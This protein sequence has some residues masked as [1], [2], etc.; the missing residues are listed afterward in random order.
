MSLV[1]LSLTALATPAIAADSPSGLSTVVI[2]AAT[3]P[4][5]LTQALPSVSVLTRVQIERSGEKNLSTLLQ[6]IAGIQITSN[7]GPGHS[8]TPYLEGFGGTDA[9]VL[10]LLDGVPLTAEDASGGGDYLE[11]LTTDQI[12]RIEVIHGNVSAIYGSGAIGGVILITTRE[13]GRKP[14]TELSLTAGSR[15]T[16]TASANA[17]GE[18]DHTR[19]QIGVS[20]YT[21]AGIPSINPAE[22][23]FVT[24]NS[25]DGY[26]NITANGSLVRELG[27]HQQLGARAFLSDGRYSYDN[28]SAGGRTKQSLL[29]IF[30][31]NR[32]GAIWTSHLSLS[33]QRT[34]NVNLGSYPATYRSTHLDVLWRNVIRISKAWTLTGGATH[35]HQSVTSA[36]QGG[37]PSVSRNVTAIFAGVNG[38]F[39]GN[40]IQLNLRHDQFDGYASTKNTYYAGYGRQLGHGFEAIV[41]YSSAF[42]VPPLGYLYYSNPYWAANPLLKP[43]SAHTVQTALQWSGR[44][45]LVRATLFQTT[46]GDMW[47]FGSTPNGLT[48][49]ANIARTRTRG[50]ELTARGTWRRWSYD[51]NVTLQ[52]PLAVS[53]PGDP[54][55]QRLARSIANVN[56]EYEFRRFAAGVLVH[57]TGPRPDVAYSASFAAIP[58]TLGSYTTVGLTADGPIGYTLRWNVSLEN[59]L[60]KRYETAYSYNSV[61]FGAFVGLT[62]SPFGR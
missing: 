62:W 43:E 22:S 29:Q 37:I 52:Q 33:R 9:G 42:N 7:G 1:L 60:D 3:F 10:I 17:S 45:N 48:E 23:P 46:G 47:G 56:V 57:Y 27:H 51:A 36:G 30:S 41:S 34:D 16:V 25:T 53:E 54:T 31:D 50:L 19:L 26:H 35:Q 40:E 5:P 24:S 28:E 55:L 14:Q 15:N 20:R 44:T 12:E 13:G 21:T 58:V 38:S 8:A 39:A 32:I 61:P 2:S 59:L 11:N 6:R 4:Q 18:I 49:F